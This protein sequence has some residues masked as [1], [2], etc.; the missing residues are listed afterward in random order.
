MALRNVADSQ[1][2]E[3]M[4]SAL[5]KSGGPMMIKELADAVGISLTTAGKY[6]DILQAGGVVS[7]KPFATAKLVTLRSSSKG[8]AG[9]GK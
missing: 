7:V 8:G 5:R 3:G 6:V 9:E 1:I 2:L 4:Q